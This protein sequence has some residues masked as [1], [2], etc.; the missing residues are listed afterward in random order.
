MNNNH[1]NFKPKHR[2]NNNNTQSKI[3]E[4]VATGSLLIIKVLILVKTKPNFKII[5]KHNS[6][7][8]LSVS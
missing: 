1:H 4:K 6:N 7:K 3:A 2:A 8:V 5:D